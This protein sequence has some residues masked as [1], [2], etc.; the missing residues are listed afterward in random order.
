[1]D[2]RIKSIRLLNFKGQRNTTV[3]FDGQSRSIFGA[4][5]TGKTTIFDAFTWALFGK[6]SKGAAQFNIKTLTPDGEIIWKLPHS[7]TVELLV[8]GKPTTIRRDFEEK[9]V[10]ARGESEET[11]RGHE[12][13]RFWNDVPCTAAEFDLKVAELCQESLF[14]LI[15][16]PAY[17]CSLDD[18]EKMR[19]LNALEG[20]TTDDQFMAATPE[21]ADFLRVLDG[22]TLDE[23]KR[24]LAGKI[25]RTKT[26]VEA[27]HTRLDEVNHNLP[28]DQDWHEIELGIVE[29]DAAIER[30]RWLQS[31]AA[32]RSEELGKERARVQ[33][34]INAAAFQ[35]RA[36][37]NAIREEVRDADYLRSAAKRELQ[38]RLEGL[39]QEQA[40]INLNAAALKARRE[41]LLA[42]LKELTAEYKA[43]HA[44]TFT[45]DEALGVCPAC[46]QALPAVDVMATRQKM[47]ERFNTDKADQMAAN[48]SDGSGVQAELKS[49]GDLL[50]KYEA[51]YTA[52]TNK[53]T[54]LEAD[55][56]LRQETRTT[57]PAPVIDADGEVAALRAKIDKLRGQLDSIPATAVPADYAAE[58]RGWQTKKS[59]LERRLY[60]RTTIAT[61][62]ARMAEIEASIKTN[63]QHLLDLECDAETIKQIQ[64]AKALTVEARINSQF[65]MVRFKMVADQINGGDRQVCEAT[66]DGV[67]YAS[68][69]NAARI[70]AGLD[71]INA[72]CHY[73][74]VTAPV[75]VDNAEAVNELMPMQSQVISLVVSKDKALTFK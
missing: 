19:M 22:K 49:N 3:E 14:R 17:F 39:R 45:F 26:E 73:Y 16:N 69:N 13:S 63:G 64:K 53:I 59:E 28:E 9:W 18:K 68:L 6:D 7:V 47:L 12:V 29:C 38:G 70:N 37:E 72:F 42:R 66:V 36:R 55:P 5:A 30:L 54:E 21:F 58:E 15:T 20:N 65:R 31:D 48:I 62:K 71:I 4:N 56:V 10:K 11:F 50:S 32:K 52:V 8:D 33:D 60:V 61:A 35:L 57:D 25:G 1:M 41:K 34:E 74:G 44:L 46:G 2:I 24:E 43:I 51:D 75:F 27:L 40:A 23:Y 67:P